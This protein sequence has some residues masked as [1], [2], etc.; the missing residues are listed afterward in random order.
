[1]KKNLLLLVF[2]LS[3]SAAAQDGNV[4]AESEQQQTEQ[5]GTSSPDPGD[6]D[7]GPGN[8]G[9]TAPINDYLPVLVL[10][11]VV[12]ILLYGKKLTEKI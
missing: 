6:Q 12:L 7:E 1:M 3:L 11:G 9:E 8:P 10:S 5:G 4:F 2:F